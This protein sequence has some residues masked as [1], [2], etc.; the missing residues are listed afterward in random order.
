MRKSG[1]PYGNST[2]FFSETVSRIYL[3]AIIQ[4]TDGASANTAVSTSRNCSSV[5]APE[6][7]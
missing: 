2:P 3:N 5:I 7:W 1:I 6:I 4:G